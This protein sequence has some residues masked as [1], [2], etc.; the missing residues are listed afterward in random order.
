MTLR[1]KMTCQI[2]AMIV[3]LLLVSG[4]ALSGLNALHQDYGVALEGYQRLRQVYE[5]GARLA[6]AQRLLRMPHPQTLRLA[7][8]EVSAAAQGFEQLRPPP[9]EWGEAVV[10]ADAAV[11]SGLRDLAGQARSTSGDS[12]DLPEPEL[13][14][15]AE[16]ERD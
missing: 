11:R 16:R 14:A 2:A 8:D 15:V 7:R 3:A 13:P 4:A 1:R 12:P 10:R 6:T 9:Q 5:A